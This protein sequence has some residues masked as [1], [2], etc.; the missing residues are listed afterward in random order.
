MTSNM[1]LVT[2]VIPAYNA[3][4]TIGE[5]IRSVRAQTHA[6]LEILIV[7]DGSSDATAEIVQSHMASDARIRLL[8]QANGGVASARNLG[9]QQAAAELIAF[10]DSDDLWSADKIEKQLAALRRG[11]DSVALVYTWYAVLDMAGSVVYNHFCPTA[12][13]EVLEELLQQNFVGN[14]SSVLIRKAALCAV[15]GYDPGLRAQRAEGCEDLL[16]YLRLAERYEFALVPEC[17]TGYRLTPASMSNNLMRMLR[18]WCLVAAE[19]CSRH[20]QHRRIV[21]QGV[22]CYVSFLLERAI[23]LRRPFDVARLGLT[24]LLRRPDLATQQLLI[25]PSRALLWKVRRTLRQKR[26]ELAPSAPEPS[27]FEIGDPD[28]TRWTSFENCPP[29]A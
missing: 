4:A 11:G 17:L 20:P 27:R 2:V 13:G 19:M 6:R 25:L 15:G 28:V 14:G 18:S 9:W 7:D 26:A 16:L 12:A 23:Q 1:E 24:L 10:V 29:A 22:T 3:A 21:A 8:R 5:T